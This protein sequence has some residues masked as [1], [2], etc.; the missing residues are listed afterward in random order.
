MPDLNG[1]EIKGENLKGVLEGRSDYISKLNGGCHP[2]DILFDEH[3]C[4]MLDNVRPLNWNDPSTIYVRI[5]YS[6]I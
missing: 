3:N 6:E 5:L 4:D 1:K 2:V